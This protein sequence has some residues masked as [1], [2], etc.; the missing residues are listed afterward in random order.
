M[1]RDSSLAQRAVELSEK[2]VR[3]KL[4]GNFV[5]VFPGATDTGVVRLAS[6]LD[7]LRVM[8]WGLRVMSQIGLLWA[9]YLS[10]TRI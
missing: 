3:M 6:C 8:C 2:I 1:T 9:S 5:P 4:T 10:R 7:Q